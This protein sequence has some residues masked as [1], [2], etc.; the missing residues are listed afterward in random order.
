MQDGPVPIHTNRHE[1]EDTDGAQ[2]H[3]EGSREETQVLLGREAHGSQESARDAQE[4]HQEVGS[5]QGHDVVVRA[6]PESPLS[7]E[8]Q[9]DQEIPDDSSDGD[10]HL[11]NHVGDIEAVSVGCHGGSGGGGGHGHIAELG[12]S[13]DLLGLGLHN[14]FGSQNP[15]DSDG[16]VMEAYGR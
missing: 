7:P 16:D 13:E 1:T 14:G 5:C 9:D 15:L 2:N 6:P 11:Q 3:Q 4:S 8:G 10:H 12:S